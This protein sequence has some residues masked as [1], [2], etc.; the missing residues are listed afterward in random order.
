MLV[1]KPSFVELL[2]KFLVE[3][4]FKQILEATVV[5]LQDRVLCAEEQRVVALQRIV[6]S[7]SCKIANRFIKVI[8]AH[9]HARA[10]KVGNLH[11]DRFASVF[12]HI[13]HRHRAFARNTKICCLVLI[14]VSMTPNHYRLSPAGH[15]LG[16]IVANN[17]LTEHHAI[18]NVSNGS[19]WRLPHL[20]QIEFFNTRFVW[21]DSRTFDAD[22][23]LQDCIC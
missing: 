10:R 8:H 12:R 11:L 3:N 19:V 9:H 4:F 5:C 6:H 7:C 15:Q 16:N 2:F 20:L 1:G 14:A 17:W 13:C 23:V 21:G 22:T 18:Q